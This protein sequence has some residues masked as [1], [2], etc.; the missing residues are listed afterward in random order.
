M[1][2]TECVYCGWALFVSLDESYLSLLEENKQLISK[3]I[4]EKCGKTNYVEHRRVGGETFGEDDERVK[5][6]EAV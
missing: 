6:L 3:H 4:C 5:R 2:I 1:L